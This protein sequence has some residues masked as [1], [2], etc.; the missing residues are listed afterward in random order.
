M[1][2]QTWVIYK[3]IINIPLRV[4]DE[5]KFNTTG[6]PR[7]RKNNLKITL[8]NITSSTARNCIGSFEYTFFN[9]VSFKT[10]FFFFH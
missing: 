9:V 1:R 6:N 7:Q 5:Y 2:T 3:Y 4:M 8:H 10:R